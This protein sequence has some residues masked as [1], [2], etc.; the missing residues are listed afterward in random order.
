MINGTQQPQSSDGQY[1]PA[2]NTNTADNHHD[3]NGKN[4][5]AIYTTTFLL[6]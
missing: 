3:D 5:F 1:P 4:V 2:T 6:Q